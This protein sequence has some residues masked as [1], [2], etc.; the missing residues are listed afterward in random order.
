MPEVN[1]CVFPLPPLRFTGGMSTNYFQI[2]AKGDRAEVLIYDEI[3]EGLFSGVSAKGLVEQLGQ[4]TAAHI[5]VR[6]NSPG[7]SVFEGSA[8]YNA[9]RRHS[10]TITIHIDGLAAS[11]ASLIA[12]AGDQIIMAENALMMIHNPWAGVVGDSRDMRDMADTLDKIKQSM[13]SAYARSG[14]NAAEIAAVMD[15]ET[16][17]TAEEAT[18]AGLA[19]EINAALPLA[20]SLDLSKFTHIPE[21]IRNMANATPET[22]AKP[23][24]NTPKLD[25]VATTEADV[26]AR[27]QARNNQITSRFTRHMDHPGV[28]A[29]YASV[30][31]D[32]SVTPDEAGNRLLEHLGA[33]AEPHGGA[34]RTNFTPAPSQYEARATYGQNAHHD[35]FRAAAAD[36]LLLRAGL[37]VKKP[38]PAA[39]DVRGMSAL[40]VASTMLGQRGQDFIGNNPNSI[41]RAAMTT[42]DFPLLL[43]DT[44]GKAL[45]VGYENE[46]ASHRLWVRDVEVDDFKPQSRVAVSEA[47]NL[48][49]IQEGA[50]YQQ[51][52]LGE[53]A[54]SYSLKTY[55]KMLVLTRRAIIND[56]LSGFTRI[57]QAFG[58]SAARKESDL[59]YALLTSNPAMSDSTALFHADHGN[60]AASGAALSVGTLGAAK[61][62]MRKQ[63]GIA[64]LGVL[65]IVP[66]YL[67]IP[68]VLETAAD[69]LLSSLVDPSKSN[70]TDNPAWIRNLQLVVDPRLDEN[71]ETAWYLAG[72]TDQ[73]DTVEVAYLREQRGVF[74]E[75]DQDF[76]TDNYRIK[77]RLDFATQVIDWVGLYKNP[78][79]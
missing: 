28:A 25:V 46:P 58:A 44:A 67:V 53:R 72:S 27:I 60:L 54:E 77:A 15:A 75:E 78:G 59:V 57:P 55:G 43:A 18:E 51:G 69:Q 62:A 37:P 13:T 21:R 6:I 3:G 22:P 40:Q 63:K 20:A 50:E 48:E 73:V 24:A 12:M 56:D 64:G 34:V 49:E 36:A 79:A 9:L 38:H 41:I 7:G 47:P 45:M 39:K 17:Y 31:N 2:K 26:L 35:E 33:Q 29:L 19:D 16:W 71:S 14:M 4:I 11:I 42:S 76:T 74:T 23:E 66:R 32:A 1:P 68:A 65:N 30:L 5:D 8:I 70:D 52:S 10:A 61:A